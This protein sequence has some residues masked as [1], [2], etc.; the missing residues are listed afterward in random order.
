MTE[1]ATT[2]EP[3]WCSQTKAAARLGIDRS[4]LC[5]LQKKHELYA[6]AR[7]GPVPGAKGIGS[8]VTQYHRDQL[9]LID[10]V[11][12]GNTDIEDA[13]L[14]WQVIKGRI[15]RQPSTLATRVTRKPYAAASPKD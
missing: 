11:L 8:M 3:L 1:N 2:E 15:G 9:R 4:L 12:V 5:K 13:W 7:R 6:P 10:G 14:E